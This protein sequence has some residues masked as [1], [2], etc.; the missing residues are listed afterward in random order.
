MVDYRRC[1]CDSCVHGLLDPEESPCDE[2]E[3]SDTGGTC[4]QPTDVECQRREIAAQE[5]LDAIRTNP[6]GIGGLSRRDVEGAA[7]LLLKERIA[8][9]ELEVL[10]RERML[11]GLV[12]DVVGEIDGTAGDAVELLKRRRVSEC[13]QLK[14]ELEGVKHD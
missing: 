8:W 2:C 10:V 5:T 14:A 13:E 1:D 3:V 4:F 9:L 11:W 7:R 12:L 6:Q